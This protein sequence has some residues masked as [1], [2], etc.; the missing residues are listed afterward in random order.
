MKTEWPWLALSFSIAL[1]LAG[2]I[3][4]LGLPPLL[5]LCLTGAGAL[6]L[7]GLRLA[8]QTRKAKSVESA[9]VHD[10]IQ[11]LIDAIPE[12]IYIKDAQARFLW[13]NHAFAEERR[14]PASEIIG[15][16]SYDLSPNPQASS[17]ISSEDAE[18]LKGGIVSKEQHTAYP[19]T[20]EECFR[21]VSK[22]LCHAPDGKP[23]VIGAHFDI[24]RLRQAE[25]R[26]QESLEREVAQRQRTQTY[27]Q[28]FVDVIPQPVYVKDANS[29]YL[30]VN[31]SFCEHRLLSAEQLIGKSPFDLSKDPAHARRVVDEDL[32]ILNGLVIAKEECMKHPVT[33]ADVYRFISKG[34]CE[35][36]DGHPVIVG[37][38]F[39]IT[40]WREAELRWQ[41]ASAAKSQ[42]LAAM[43]HEIRTPLSGVI[44]MLQLA[45]TDRTLEPATRERLETGLS[46]A[47][48]LLAIIS[49]IL[50]FSKIEAGQL[51]LEQ[52]DF[53]LQATVREVLQSFREQAE[54]R[55][56]HLT[57]E[58][59]PQIPQ[60][61]CGDPTRIRQV[62]INLIGNALKFTEQGEI[63]VGVRANPPCN[64]RQQVL[65][66][67]RDTGIGI[68]AEEI[69]KLFQ[70][71]QQADTSTTRRFGGTGLGLAI[72]RQLVEAMGGRISVFS[73]PGAGSTFEFDLQLAPGQA[74]PAAINAELPPHQR[75]LHVLCAEDVRVNQLIIR[76]QLLRMG[77]SVD[78]VESGLAA[79][80]ALAG[81]DYDLVLMDGRMPE[82]DGA[83][84]TRAIRTGGLPDAPVRNP[85]VRIVALTA[86]ASNEDR[87]Q[88]LASGMDDY[89]TKPIREAQLHAALTRTI[90]LLEG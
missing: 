81:K 13:V 38:N 7:P 48:S 51:Q 39:D 52:I 37:A 11:R 87:E 50:D 17:L 77:H 24:T 36:A 43:S 64:G 90:E 49:D 35:D 5:A 78:M 33:G 67:I 74:P 72:C 56:L 40:A 8:R 86:N 22:R 80:H 71:F 14:R 31:Q 18:V 79:I 63:S 4:L 60:H 57:L 62:L 10:F 84:A 16:S 89:L 42:F 12:P 66:S 53:D 45:I 83:D 27:M 54:Q 25:I 68:A 46:S 15:L 29:R 6:V 73:T 20:G 23:L 9:E 88:Y 34:S 70:M 58:L 21:L 41:H 44:G 59:D 26:M 30:L 55:A 76:T 1:L 2:G 61:V 69:P 3:H 47:E 82:M 85:A 75:K 19:V 65:F 28:R 32:E